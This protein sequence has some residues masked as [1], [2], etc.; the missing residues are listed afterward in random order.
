NDIVMISDA[1]SVAPGPRILF[2]NEA[3]VRTSGYSREEVIGQSPEHLLH[4]PSTDLATVE[5]I[6]A[7]TERGDA[8]HVEIV[9]HAKNGL[10]YW[11][12]ME[13]VPVR[14]GGAEITHFVAVQRDITERKQQEAAL[15]ELNAE[16]ESRVRSR[17]EELKIARD[18]A[19][20]ANRA[21]SAFLATMSHE[22]RTPMNGVI[23]MVEV[24]QQAGLRREQLEMVDLIRD[25]AFSLLGII[26]SIL[27][28]SKIEAGQFSLEH[29]AL[30][31]PAL[32]EKVCTLQDQAAR[33]R[34]VRLNY[35]VDPAVPPQL[36]G[37]ETRIR[38]ILVNLIG[39]AVKFS[40]G[41]DEPG[42]VRVSMHL[43]AQ[44]GGRASIELLVADN[45]IGMDADTVSRLFKPFSQA[46]ASTTRR[47]GGT[48]LGLAIT[49]NLVSLMQGSIAVD[50]RPGEGTS[51]RV[52]LTLDLP[53]HAQGTMV[54]A[55]ERAETQPLPLPAL[56]APLTRDE[57]LQQGRLIL[58]AEDNETNCKVIRHQLAMIGIDADI[59]VNGREALERWRSHRYAL[60]LTDLH[61]PEMDGYELAAAIRAEEPHGQRTPILALTANAM[62]SEEQRC[63]REGMDGYL[64]KPIRLPQLKQALEHWLRAATPPLA[65]PPLPAAAPARSPVVREAGPADLSVLT[66]LVGDDV[67]IMAELLQVFCGNAVEVRETLRQGVQGGRLENAMDQAHKLKSGARSIGAWRLADLCVAIEAT[68]PSGS[69]GRLSSLIAELDAEVQAV[70]EYVEQWMQSQRSALPADALA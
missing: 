16:L 62:R 61:M 42:V 12:E 29:Q 54:V 1:S 36:L 2:V 63:L 60:V 28:F 3:F 10:P 69:A 47:F 5:R 64:T 31:L 25:S 34:G 50:S 44:Q 6:R 65:R 38:Q 9:N 21:K 52:N 7:A 30:C 15:R 22:I 39:N 56:P 45:G 32:V 37:D 46:D 40:S 49:A 27:D 57:A 19:Q 66:D 68:G 55:N 43:L 33:G 41:C 8:C 20:Q 17:T 4:G 23:G 51:F 58:V 53:S 35:L 14:A 70:L 48:G 18:E 67:R 13:I 26:D 59:A 24:L 11:V